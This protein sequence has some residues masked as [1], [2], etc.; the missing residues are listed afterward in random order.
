[1]C[2]LPEL[3]NRYAWATPSPDALRIIKEFSPIVE[4]GCGANAYW[5]KIMQEE[6]IDVV[7]Y[8]IEIGDGGKIIGKGSSKKHGKKQQHQQQQQEQ[9]S[10]KIARKGGPT[11]LKEHK[12]RTLFLCYPDEEG[13]GMGA[14]CLEHYDGEYV[15]HVGESILDSNYSMDQ[16]P[17]G[18]S[19]SS[20]FQERLIAEYHCLIKVEIP[21][22]LH[23]RDTI[24][25]W[26]RSRTCTI[27]FAADSDDDGEDEDEEIEYRHIPY[28]ERLPI[29]LAAPCCAHLLPKVTTGEGTD[30]NGKKQK[31]GTKEKEEN[32]EE[33]AA[34]EE[35][36]VVQKMRSNSSESSEG[37]KEKK[38][39][40]KKRKAPDQQVLSPVFSPPGILGIR[41]RER[42]DSTDSE[43]KSKKHKHGRGRS[44]SL[45][46][47]QSIDS[48]FEDSDEENPT[49]K[50]R[51]SYGNYVTPW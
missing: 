15:I 13:E 42:A 12:D 44:H 48:L 25:V 8:D 32:E 33:A 16:A 20:D 37:R 14:E 3:V 46:S 50:Y 11:M 35:V 22:W 21:N 49:A 1:M 41:S 5:A 2:L 7:A 34:E 38:K 18:R 19:S 40:T 29:N 6:G 9:P 10:T 4:I 30:S 27:V 31:N 24:S 47:H 23:V 43:R 26:K 45:G 51:I 36:P 17:W 28:N 39:K